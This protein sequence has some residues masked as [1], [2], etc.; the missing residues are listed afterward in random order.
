MGSPGAVA[1]TAAERRH[2]LA[3]LGG[4]VAEAGPIRTLCETQD[5]A[6]LKRAYDSVQPSGKAVKRAYSMLT[7]EAEHSRFQIAVKRIPGRPG[8]GLYPRARRGCY[9]AFLRS[10][11]PVS[12]AITA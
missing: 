8:L 3:E 1:A 9:A 4:A 6:S 5:L 7:P 10:L 11:G 2:E 12:F